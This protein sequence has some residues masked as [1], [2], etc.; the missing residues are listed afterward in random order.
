M[1]AQYKITLTNRAFNQC[2]KDKFMH[3]AITTWDRL[4][5]NPMKMMVVSGTT[6]IQQLVHYLD[7]RVSDAD[8]YI[9]N[10]SFYNSFYYM[11]F[12]YTEQVPP[13]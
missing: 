7:I 10:H 6:D 5:R 11:L 8:I 4:A 3:M 2:N 1:T 13:F 9:Y 12:V